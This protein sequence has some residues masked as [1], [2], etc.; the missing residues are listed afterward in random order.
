M[1]IFWRIKPKSK[2]DIWA[3]S[4]RKAK[5]VR[6]SANGYLNHRL[7][8]F[9]KS[10]GIPTQDLNIIL[11]LWIMTLLFSNWQA[12]WPLM[13]MLNLPV[14]HLPLLILTLAL[15]KNNAT[16]VVGEVCHQVSSK[17]IYSTNRFYGLI[18]F[19]F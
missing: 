10:F 2:S 12:L 19:I 1:A 15:L 16:L 18:H 14:C 4:N 3:Q 11:K 13:M 17:N 5:Y 7:S 9:H 6:R 8:I